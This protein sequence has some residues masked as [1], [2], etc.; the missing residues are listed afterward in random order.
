MKAAKPSAMPAPFLGGPRLLQARGSQKRSCARAAPCEGCS[1]FEA[2]GGPALEEA[3]IGDLK[4][5]ARNSGALWQGQN[6]VDLCLWLTVARG[7]N[8]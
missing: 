3:E 4:M 5:T 8:P 2:R 1:E 7:A 6:E